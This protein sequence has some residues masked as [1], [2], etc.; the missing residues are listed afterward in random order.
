MPGQKAL[1]CAQRLSHGS[2]EERTAT[3][4]RRR[5]LVS[6]RDGAIPRPSDRLPE[7][8]PATAGDVRVP[9]SPRSLSLE[10]IGGFE[11]RRLPPAAVHAIRCN[12]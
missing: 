8:L 4:K 9:R 5:G 11:W 1:L 3:F 7:T 12:D 10:T 6:E 2:I